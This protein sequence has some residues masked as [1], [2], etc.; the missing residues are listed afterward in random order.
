MVGQRIGDMT[1]EELKAWVVEVV[2]ERLRYWPGEKPDDRSPEEVFD[3]IRKNL[4]KRKPGRP[5]VVEMIR[6]DRDR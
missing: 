3:S 5:S 1:Q 2:E 4:I 6:E